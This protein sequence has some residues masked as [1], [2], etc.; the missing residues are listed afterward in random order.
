VKIEGC[1][2]VV[3]GGA[4][5]IGLA[6]CRALAEAGAAEVIVADREGEAAEAAARSI[7]GQARTIDVRERGA[8]ERLIDDIERERG[9]IDLFCS[10]AGV[11]TGFD[12]Y[13][14]A[15]G[16]DDEVW[17]AAWEI[18]TL[19]HVRAARAL[20][21]RMKARGGG[22]FLN[23][24]S[25]AG[26]LNQIGSA[27]Y[28]TTKHAAIGFAE[29]LAITH[30]DDKI[31]VSVLCPQGVD[32]RMLRGVTT[33]PQSLDGVLSADEVAA[34]ALEGVRNETFLILPHPQVQAYMNNKSG[35]MQRWL[36]GMTKLQRKI[37]AAEAQAQESA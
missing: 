34:A 3:T 23:T 24:V 16:P 27:V 7:G 8:I 30:A 13:D 26:L 36:R 31:R 18:N 33:G 29:N 19:A 25:A 28:A 35:D 15:A 9:A 17:Q 2:A 37:R 1:R 20:A 5:G 4:N 12:S 14:N 11:A 21:P 6:L 10:N 22:Y 32:T